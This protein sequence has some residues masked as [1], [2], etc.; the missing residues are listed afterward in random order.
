MMAIS[1][2]VHLRKLAIHFPV[3]L[4]RCDDFWWLWTEH[5]YDHDPSQ[6]ED[7]AKHG[8]V[9]DV[10]P[11]FCD[12][13]GPN[14][15][16]LLSL[17]YIEKHWQDNGPEARARMERT[18]RCILKID[19]DAA[20]DEEDDGLFMRVWVARNEHY[21]E[22][23]VRSFATSGCPALEEFEWYPYIGP[24]AIRLKTRWLWK[25][26]RDKDGAVE[27]VSGDFTW[28]GGQQPELDP[29]P[30]HMFVGEELGRVQRK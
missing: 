9:R 18:A 11:P 14:S 19:D 29:P 20:L 28:T 22:A 27:R 17:R 15:V 26:H 10:C 12:N 16:N 1:N 21:V 2:L 3:Y 7:P 30:F 8:V 24:R 23:A 25:V 13:G 5:D 4:Y 6:S